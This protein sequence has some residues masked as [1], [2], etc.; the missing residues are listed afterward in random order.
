MTLAPVITMRVDAALK[1]RID[2]AAKV[3]GLDRSAWIVRAIERDLEGRTLAPKALPPSAKPKAR[4]GKDA[5][6][7]A[8]KLDTSCVMVHPSLQKRRTR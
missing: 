6:S 7:G 4:K 8:T 3:A 5:V 1:Q 2:A